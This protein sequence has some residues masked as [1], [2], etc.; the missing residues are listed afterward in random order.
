[1]TDFTFDE[2]THTYRYNGKVVPSVT[3]ILGSWKLIKYG[4]SEFY[5]NTIDGTVVDKETFEAAGDKGTSIHKG[6]PLVLAGTLDW[7]ELDLSLL[8]PLRQLEEWQ[9]DM[10]P[11]VIAVEKPLYSEKHGYAGTPD[12]VCRIGRDVM[13][14]DFKSGAYGCAGPQLAAYVELDKENTGYKG[15]ACYR[16]TMK[17]FVLDLS[18]KTKSYKFIRQENPHDLDFFRARHYQFN[19]LQ[20]VK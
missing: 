16:G 19:Y 2:P 10:K 11:E 5:V 13:I 6:A 20:G 7:D 4:S 9:K 1:M 17:R 15:L 8:V 12:L 18:G 14:V 3:T